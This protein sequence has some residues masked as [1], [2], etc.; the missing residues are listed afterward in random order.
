V[1]ATLA[2]PVAVLDA[3]VLVPAGLRD[4]LLSC[5]DAEVFRPVWQRELE[6]E[7][8]RNATR[9]RLRRGDSDDEAAAYAQRVLA[10]MNSAFPDARLRDGAW[11][12]RTAEMTNHP[13]DRHVLAA[14]V[15]AKASHV[16]TANLRDFPVA[17]RPTGVL[18]QAPERFLL[19]RLRDDADGVR[20]A[21]EAM[22]G[23]HARP[24]HTSRELASLMANGRFV[25]RFG[26]ALL[27]VL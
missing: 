6:A 3:S 17:S 21:V 24:V 22:A 10:A 20:R 13:K 18:V 26:T 12:P 25:P 23:R 16:V 5:A 4:L 1:P 7:I 2:R 11:Q 8:L 19:D 9:L 14:A 27:E 15:A